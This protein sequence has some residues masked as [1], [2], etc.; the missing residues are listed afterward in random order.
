MP[1]FIQKC[2]DSWKKFCPD[3]EIIRWDETNLDIEK[4]KFAKDA[5]ENKKWAFFS[6]V[7]RFDILNTY[8]G[9][10]LDVD[11]ELL[12]S[13]DK[14]LD[15][16]FFTGFE[17]SEYV[18]PGLIM[19][20]KPNGKVCNDV[21]EKYNNLKFDKN[22]LVTVCEIVTDYLK[23]QHNLNL[24][25]E[26]QFLDNNIRIYSPEYFCPKNFKTGEIHKT[27]NSVSIHHYY[28]SWVPKQTIFSKFKKGV[29]NLV[30]KIIGTKNVEKIKA[31]R[32]SKLEKNNGM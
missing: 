13:L 23:Q 30:K 27:E 14:F 2:I 19:G 26:T 20:S 18:A 22:H 7:H 16:D 25:G 9:I 12:G 21:I 4:F 8:G 1:E 32:K 17:D 3:Y 29:K 28:A 6:D 15:C 10:Y 11:V 31:K 5:Y 24:N